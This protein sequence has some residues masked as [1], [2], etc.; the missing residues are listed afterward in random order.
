[1]S[2]TLTLVRLHNSILVWDA[3]HHF[4]ALTAMFLPGIELNLIISLRKIDTLV[5]LK[6]TL[7]NSGSVVSMI[8]DS[9]RSTRTVSSS[10]L[11]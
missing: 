5:T 9:S 11:R 6:S 2:T 10:L 8:G 3:L 4:K 1:M 7:E